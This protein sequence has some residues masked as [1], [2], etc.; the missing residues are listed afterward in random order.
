MRHLF[1]TAAVSALI[2]AAPVAAGVPGLAWAQT[3]APPAVA[4]PS[5]EDARFIGFL[6]AEFAQE[7]TMRPQLATRLGLKVGEDRLDDISDAG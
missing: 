3:S 7:L 1:R 4:S 2:L 6:D 5:A